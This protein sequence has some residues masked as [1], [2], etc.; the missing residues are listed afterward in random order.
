MGTPF[1]KRISMVKG[2]HC[3]ITFAI[4]GHQNESW[5]KVEH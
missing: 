3:V 4:C 1:L 5:L 2:H